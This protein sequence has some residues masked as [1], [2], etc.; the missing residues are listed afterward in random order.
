MDSS[1]SPRYNTRHQQHRRP[2][3]LRIADDFGRILSDNSLRVISRT[4]A[5]SSDN[6]HRQTREL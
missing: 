2:H 6:L 1:L 4:G 5:D 3:S